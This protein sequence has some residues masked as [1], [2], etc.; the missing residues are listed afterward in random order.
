MS[1][2][3]FSPV[4]DNSKP[5]THGMS[6]YRGISVKIK[7]M[8]PIGPAN[9]LPIHLNSPS[10]I[11][12]LIFNAQKPQLHILKEIEKDGHFLSFSLQ[13][14][15]ACYYATSDTSGDYVKPGYI[16][17]VRFP[18]IKEGFT[19]GGSE[20]YIFEC[21]DGTVWLDMRH[22]PAQWYKAASRT[23]VDHELLLLRGNVLA[24]KPIPVTP[25]DCDKRFLPWAKNGERIII[26]Q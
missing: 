25:A 19:F 4:I 15:V 13:R 14:K 9:P 18:E 20:P 26:K 23:I 16:T 3:V 10:E 8:T 17:T 7:S 1:P 6:L 22:L 21:Y 12:G 2:L 5:I 24:S 11:V